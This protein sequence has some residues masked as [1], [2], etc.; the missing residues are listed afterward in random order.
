MGALLGSPAP[1]L[2][3]SSLTPVLHAPAALS[4]VSSAQ[5]PLGFGG[6][7]S[8]FAAAWNLPGQQLGIC[9]SF[10]VFPSL[11]A[12]C[13]SIPGVQGPKTRSFVLSIVVVQVGVHL[14]LDPPS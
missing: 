10:L 7:S 8:R 4:S 6:V 1:S 2:H 11:R 13:P 12:H 9:R 14:A 5:H 3:L